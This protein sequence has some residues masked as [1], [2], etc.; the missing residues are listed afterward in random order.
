MTVYII[1]FDL[2][3]SYEVNIVLPF[4]A[5]SISEWGTRWCSWLRPCAASRKVVD[6]I[7][8]GVTGIFP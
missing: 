7:P 4:H 6:L 3:L 5:C 8:D 2:V 1:I